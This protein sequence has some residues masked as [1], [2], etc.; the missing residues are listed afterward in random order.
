MACGTSSS[1]KQQARQPAQKVAD[2]ITALQRDLGT[3]NYRDL[4]EQVFSSEARQQAGGVSCPQIVAREST[5]IRGPQIDVKGIDVNGHRATAKVV[6][7]A[8]GQAAVPE[9]IDLVWENGAW[10][11]SA[12]AAR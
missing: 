6:T 5:G 9:T 4:C 1:P 10:R 7:S 12:L 8:A 3:R 11:V 2:A